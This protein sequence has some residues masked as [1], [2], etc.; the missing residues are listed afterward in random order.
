MI[1][2]W[3]FYGLAI[4]AEL[5]W[6]VLIIS[7]GFTHTTAVSCWVDLGHIL[8]LNDLTHIS[9]NWQWNY[10][11]PEPRKLSQSFS[12]GS[13]VPEAAR[14]MESTFKLLAS[15]M[16]PN[17]LLAKGS[18]MVKARFTKL[19]NVFLISGAEKYFHHF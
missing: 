16:F 4:W 19:R 18:H 3:P 15:I 10:L 7:A 13:W 6:P 1:I 5:S 14:G 2:I 9:G 12:Q 8:V 11:S 17:V